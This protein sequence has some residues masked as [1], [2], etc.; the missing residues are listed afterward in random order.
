MPSSAWWK[1]AFSLRWSG[2]A[3]RVR[4]KYSAT[5]S[6]PS[7]TSPVGDDLVARVVERRH[8]H[9]EVVDVLGLHVLAHDG[10]AAL[11]QRRCR[12]VHQDGS[13]SGSQRSSSWFQLRDRRVGRQVVGVGQLGEHAAR[14]LGLLA[15]LRV[16][17]DLVGVRADRDGVA[18]AVARLARHP[19]LAH[20]VEEAME[21]VAVLD[22]EL[23][24]PVIGHGL[25]LAHPA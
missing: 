12:L 24:A 18:E 6:G 7:K 10:L 15:R 23:N 25:S 3:A 8:R 19:A 16:G 5:S 13:P 17:E 11:A 9:V 22:V 20:A 14:V 1:T 21:H 4:R 2:N